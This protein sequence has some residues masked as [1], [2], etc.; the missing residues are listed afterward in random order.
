MRLRN[1]FSDYV[2]KLMLEMRVYVMEC[3]DELLIAL[4]IGHVI[5]WWVIISMVPLIISK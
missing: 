5:Q 4:L 1:K 3:R 2:R